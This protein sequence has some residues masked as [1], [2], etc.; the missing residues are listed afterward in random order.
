[1]DFQRDELTF[2]DPSHFRNARGAA[3]PLILNE[4]GNG[5][6]LEAKVDGI[7]GR[8]QLDSGNE[9]GFFLNAAFVDQYHLPTR[10]HAT[11][12]GWNGK[13]LGGDSPD[14]WFTRLHRLELGSVILRDPVVRLQTGD[15]HD[16][17]KLAG[18]I[19]QSILKHFTV[20]VDC[21]HRLM[22]L[23]QVPGWDAPEVFN[24]AGLIYDEQAGGDEIKT[25]LPGGPAQL[26]GLRPG[27][28]ITAINGNKPLEEGRIQ[29]SRD[30]LEL[31][32]TCLSAETASSAPMP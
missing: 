29:S 26:A 5:V 6:Y 31:C 21:P 16:V 20:I 8:F 13:G 19:G 18:N 32:C 12:R 11:L 3:V 15:D 30:L 17:Q 25:V 10:L 28:L 24:R 14:A 4:H 27:D 1:M 9:I 2:I 22:Y 7:P 23:E